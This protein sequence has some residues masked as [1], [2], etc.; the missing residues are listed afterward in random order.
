[1]D[2][3]FRKPEG[4]VAKE[5]EGYDL[6][7]AMTAQ[8]Q[9]S[10]EKRDDLVPVNTT[11]AERLPFSK[12]RCITLVAT[13]AA[14]P[15]LSTF[16]VQASVIILPT[17]GEALDIPTSRQQWIVSAY[18]LT[19][20]CFL[21]LWG[22]L[23]DVYG[24]RLIFLWGSAFFSLTSIITPF[25]LNEIGF[26][27][28]RG[29]QGLAAAAMAPTAL[30][31]LGVTFPPGKT[32]DIAFGCFGAGAPLGGIMGNIFG[33]VVGEASQLISE[34]YDDTQ[35]TSV[36]PQLEVGLLGIRYHIR[37]LH[38]RELF[39]HSYSATAT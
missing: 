3:G 1:M 22:R 27:I 25:V 23:A 35:L 20:G 17:I 24:R 16:A 6:E 14:A 34:L 4:V 9:H 11:E 10:A 8:Q 18:S 26:D 39:R 7:R 13:I 33:G 19:F 28:L 21:L 2:N 32:K 36:V 15:F 30:G 5:K 29:L 38:R 37:D 12:A 31:I